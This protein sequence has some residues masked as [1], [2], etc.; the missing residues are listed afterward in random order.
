MKLSILTVLLEH[1]VD[2]SCLTM[3]D[4]DMLKEIVPKVG[5]RAKLKTNIAEWRKVI[6]LASCSETNYTVII[7]DIFWRD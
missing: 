6:E 7:L 5:D 1:G 4:E 2:I 3:L